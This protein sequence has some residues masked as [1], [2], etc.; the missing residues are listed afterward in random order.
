[1]IHQT[2]TGLGKP[3]INRHPDVRKGDKVKSMQWI[4]RAADS[5]KGCKEVL[6]WKFQL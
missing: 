1:M 4:Q 5:R 3:V 2:V 6:E